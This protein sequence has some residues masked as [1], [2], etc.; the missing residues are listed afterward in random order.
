MRPGALSRMI[1]S[2]KEIAQMKHLVLAAGL[3][4]LAFAAPVQAA[5]IDGFSVSTHSLYF[6]VNDAGPLPSGITATTPPPEFDSSVET[7]LDAPDATLFEDSDINIDGTDQNNPSVFRYL[8]STTRN[9]GTEGAFAQ[10]ETRLFGTVAFSPEPPNDFVERGIWGSSNAQGRI[11]SDPFETQALSSGSWQ[12][13]VVF[14]NDTLLPFFFTLSGHLEVTADAAFSGDGGFAAA[15]ASTA[16]LFDSTHDLDISFSGTAPYSPVEDA[17]GRNATAEIGRTID[18]ANSGTLSLTASARVLG[19]DPLGS[20]TG[21][22]FGRQEYLLGITLQTGE[23]LTMRNLSTYRNEVFVSPPLPAIPLPGSGLLLGTLAAL[24]FG[25]SRARRPGAPASSIRTHTGK[26]RQ[27]CLRS[28]GV[29]REKP[30]RA[31]GAPVSG[32]CH[33]A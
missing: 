29:D 17:T 13:D 2:Q 20:G 19:D 10:N 6:R 16:L 23:T 11:D 8:E 5:T 22:V 21:S 18:L 7:Q 14:T 1:P 12:R 30:N 9:G 25:F 3:T 32:Q 4:A 28:G 27:P 24:G 15:F 26:P 31:F 33:G